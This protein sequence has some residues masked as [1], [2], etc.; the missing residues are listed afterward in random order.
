M[1]K[2]GRTISKK[3]YYKTAEL[4]R[5]LDTSRG[6]L[7]ALKDAHGNVTN[8]TIQSSVAEKFDTEIII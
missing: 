8:N 6:R 3:L 4:K 5:R 2:L 1:E 7:F